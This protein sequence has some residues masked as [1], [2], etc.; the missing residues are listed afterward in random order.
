MINYVHH[1]NILTIAVDADFAGPGAG[2]MILVVLAGSTP[3]TDIFGSPVVMTTNGFVPPTPP[4]VGTWI[5][6]T[7]G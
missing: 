1:V 3:G 2:C 4:V 7:M 6:L 5:T